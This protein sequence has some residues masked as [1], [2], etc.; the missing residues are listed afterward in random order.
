MDSKVKKGKPNP[1]SKKSLNKQLS[2]YGRSTTDYK[3]RPSAVVIDK[4]TGKVSSSDKQRNM[5]DKNIT[6]DVV[7]K[8]LPK[9]SIAEIK[10]LADTGD[11]VGLTAFQKRKPD[12]M[13]KKEIQKWITI[14]RL[15][16]KV[17]LKKRE[18]KAKKSR[19][20]KSTT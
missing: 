20:K 10:K 14:N 8:K 13:S 6:Y 2:W 16:A 11:K 12:L 19:A 18:A 15:A 17:E 5:E 4:K 1:I 7:A 9:L 3:R